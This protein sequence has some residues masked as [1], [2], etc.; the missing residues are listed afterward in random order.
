MLAFVSSAGCSALSLF[1]YVKDQF[2]AACYT[3]LLID[4]EEIIVD[5]VFGHA[6]FLGDL[7]IW[8]ALS[9]QI[10]ELVLPFGQ[11]ATP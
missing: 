1:Q 6:E 10:D 3:E 7:T 11:K 9:C 8:Q 4:S 5:R 2:G